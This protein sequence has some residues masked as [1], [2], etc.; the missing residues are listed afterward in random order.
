M[1]WWKIACRRFGMR[2]YSILFL[3]SNTVLPV[4]PPPA[5]IVELASQFGGYGYRGITAL[6]LHRDWHVNYKRVE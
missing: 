6:L 2:L 4:S 5:A 1:N 3:Q